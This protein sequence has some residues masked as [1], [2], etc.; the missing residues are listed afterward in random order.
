MTSVNV[1]AGA[2][3]NFPLS[4][5][6]IQKILEGDFQGATEMGVIDRLWN[7][8]RKQDALNALGANFQKTDRN[9]PVLIFEELSK[10]LRNPTDLQLM[11]V[12]RV[13]GIT[14]AML[15][16]ISWSRG[17]LSSASTAANCR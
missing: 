16:C 7:G 17:S 8:S 4:Q 14:M 6:R 10:H 12:D 13:L 5:S 3:T 1:N 9:D 11:N 2:T 15:M